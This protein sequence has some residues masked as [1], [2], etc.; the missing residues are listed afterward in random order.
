MLV[1]TRSNFGGNQFWRLN[2]VGQWGFGERCIERVGGLAARSGV[3]IQ[4]CDVQPTGPW[5]YLNATRQLRHRGVGL[6]LDGTGA[7]LHLVEC[8]GRPS[9]QVRQMSY[10]PLNVTFSTL[11]SY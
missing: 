6:C 3:S 1:C 7:Q 2:V 5:Q 11:Y 4:Y 10:D 8:V 9:Q